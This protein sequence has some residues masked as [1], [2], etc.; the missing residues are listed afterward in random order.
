M[1]KA[2]R[3]T[4]I[5]GEPTIGLP[6]YNVVT[7]PLDNAQTTGSPKE[8]RIPGDRLTFY[9]NGDMAG[10]QF[11]LDYN[12]DW[13]PAGEFGNPFFYPA[14]FK[15]F[16]LAWTA[17]AGKYLRVFV[18]REA[19]A[20]TSAEASVQ[21]TAAAPKVVFDTIVSD[22]DVHFTLGLLTGIKEDE[23]LTGLIANK[24]RI[25]NIAIQANQNLD[26]WLMF[27]RR[28]AFDNPDLDIDTFIGAVELDLS[29]FGIQVGGANQWYMSLEAV[30]LD[31]EDEDNNYE[32]HVSLYNADA[33]AKNAG[34]IGEVVVFIKYELRA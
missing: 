16:F 12:N 19:A 31:Y 1:N 3:S 2:L 17:Q 13:I 25:T 7:I 11:A 28:N 5:P 14:K 6:P 18:G 21:I 33:I 26:Y 24:L 4:V 27:W 10:I 22:K 29:T 8:V 32:L 30:D 9:T 23:N 20:G 15:T 34:A